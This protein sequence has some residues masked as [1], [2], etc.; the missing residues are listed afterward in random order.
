MPSF[1]RTTDPG[2]RRPAWLHFAAALALL[3]CFAPWARADA[4]DGEASGVIEAFH[5]DLVSVMKEAET[6]GYSGRFERIEP[7][8]RRTFDLDF[9][10]EK[11]V[12]SRHWRKLSE[13]DQARMRDV[14]ARFTIATYASRFSGFGGE[15]FDVLAEQ[16][17]PRD[18]VFVR[19]RLVRT[20][21]EKPVEINYR[22]LR[23]DEGWRV[24]DVLLR[25]TVSELALRRAEYSS[26]IKRDGFEKLI[27]TLEE[28]IADLAAGKVEDDLS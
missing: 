2:A 28:K 20:D 22:M 26:M 24:I 12:S 25:G 1:H 9:M 6:L 3:L 7:A 17:A 10:A 23:G 16:P 11:A 8:L 15:R 21:G 19:T 5:A 4:I 13:A 14:F 18:T 27:E